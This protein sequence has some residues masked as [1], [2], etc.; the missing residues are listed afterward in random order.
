MHQSLTN[1]RVNWRVGT[2]GRCSNCISCHH[3]ELNIRPKDEFE[4]CH[5]RFILKYLFG[6]LKMMDTWAEVRRPCK[7]ANR[8]LCGQLS[9]SQCLL[10]FAAPWTWAKKRFR[11]QDK[12]KK[13]DMKQKWLRIG[14]KKGTWRKNREWELKGKNTGVQEDRKRTLWLDFPLRSLAGPMSAWQRF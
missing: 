7:W 12:N 2:S 6:C 3:V 8:P 9:Y 11:A 5:H 4:C 14:C 13:M 1:Y 10:S